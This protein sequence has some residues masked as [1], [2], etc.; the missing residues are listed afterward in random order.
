MFDYQI[1]STPFATRPGP[2]VKGIGLI[3]KLVHAHPK[4]NRAL[5][6]ASGNFPPVHVGIEL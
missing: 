1:L 6:G 5:I 2:L 4:P 3:L